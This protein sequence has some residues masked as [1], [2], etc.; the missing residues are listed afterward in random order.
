MTMDKTDLTTETTTEENSE[1][2]EKQDS[3]FKEMWGRFKEEVEKLK[4]T[5]PEIQDISDFFRLAKKRGEDERRRQIVEK[6]K[7]DENVMWITV[8]EYTKALNCG[9][10]T[11]RRH[12][13]NNELY[14]TTIKT[15]SGKDKFLIPI[16]HEVVKHLVK[17]ER[18]RANKDTEITIIIDRST[19][20]DL[21]LE[22]II[23]PRGTIPEFTK[24]KVRIKTNDLIKVLKESLSCEVIEDQP[25]E[26]TICGE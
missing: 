3:L 1:E 15:K 8:K 9:E 17:R 23:Q 25:P 16:T 18:E 10:T 12:I 5:D 20:L 7:K 21:E 14:Y 6:L 13:K 11:V 19:A 4:E 26:T 22:K 2:K 24:L